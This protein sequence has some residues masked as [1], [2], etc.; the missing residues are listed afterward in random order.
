MSIVLERNSR[1]AVKRIQ[2][3]N[4][5]T[6]SGIEHAAFTSGRG[7]VKATSA[8]I[9]KKPKGGRTYIKRD[10]T[11]RGRRH[12]ASAPGETH[13]NMTGTLRRSLSFKVNRRKLEFGYGV[14]GNNAPEYAGF[15]EFGTSIMKPRPSLENGIKG[16]RRNIQNNFDREIGKRLEG[17]GF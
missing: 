3:L 4:R 10:R 11:G 16:E 5:L 13:A 17:R 12:V 9:L 7:L 6:Q 14:Q 1:K 15:V 2:G 8:E